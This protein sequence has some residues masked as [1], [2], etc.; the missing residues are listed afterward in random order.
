MNVSIIYIYNKTSI[1]LYI[2]TIKKIHREVDRAKDLSG[3]RYI[4]KYMYTNCMDQSPLKANPFPAS[5]EIPLILWN[6][7]FITAFTSARHLSLP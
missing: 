7:N 1:K 2:L 4:Y 5:Q 6:L 3:P